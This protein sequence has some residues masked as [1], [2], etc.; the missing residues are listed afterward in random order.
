MTLRAAPL[1]I[2][3]LVALL[4][5]CGTPGPPP[6]GGASVVYEVLGAGM[7]ATVAYS[8]DGHGELSGK[9]SAQLPWSQTVS[10]PGSARTATLSAA[11]A[12][13]GELTCRITVDGH[14]AAEVTSSGDRVVV[15]CVTNEF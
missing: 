11:N 2:P 7:A 14:V 4:A 10:M 1:A 15:H 9:S 13:L 8:S 5:G 12:G 6:T 3:A